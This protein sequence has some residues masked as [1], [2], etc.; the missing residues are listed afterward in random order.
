MI[1]E[2]IGVK[3]ASALHSLQGI[4]ACETSGKFHNKSKEHWVK[5]LIRKSNDAELLER[6]IEF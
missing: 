6:L 5:L 2:F 3:R 4:T 1:H